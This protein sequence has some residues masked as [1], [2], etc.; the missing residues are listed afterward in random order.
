M[1]NSLR[2]LI[3]LVYALFAISGFAGLIYEALWSRYMKLLLGH[4]AYGQIL[5]LILFMGGV[6]VGSWLGGKYARILRHPLYLYALAEILIGIGGLSYHALYQGSSHLLFQGASSLAG[7]PMLLN[8]L[9]LSLAVLITV[10]WA[11]LLGVTFPALAIGLLEWQAD[12]GQAALPWLYFTNSLGGAAGVLVSSF[13]LLPHLGTPGT[14]TVAASLNLLLGLCF[15]GLVRQ[16]PQQSSG[17]LQA[18]SLH[19]PETQQASPRLLPEVHSLLEPRSL[20]RVLLV[21]SLLTGLSS[22]IYEI[23]WIRLLSLLIG[24]STQA[25]DLMLSAFILGLAVGSLVVRFV[26]KHTLKPLRDLVL[27]QWAMG[28]L[29][30][31]SLV[32]YSGIFELMNQSHAVFLRTEAAYVVFS[33]FRY[34]ICLLLMFPA[35][36]FAGMT[37]PLISWLVLRLSGQ[38]RTLGQVYALNT[39]GA[40]LGAALGGLVLMPWLQLKGTLLA[41][42]LIDIALAVGLACLMRVSLW[43]WAG[44]VALS[45]LLLWPVLTLQLNSFALSAGLFREAVDLQAQHQSHVRPPVIR[46]GR[47]ATISFHDFGHLRVLKTNGKPDASLS[48]QPDMTQANDEITQVALALYPMRLMKQPY[49]AAMIGMGSGMTAHYL[50][51]DPW[52]QKLDLIE[53][54][55]EV[56][57]LARGFLP[58]NRQ[59]YENPRLRMIFDDARTFFHRENQKYDLIVSEP[60]NPWVSGVSSLFTTEF[61]RDLKPFLKPDGLL[62]QWIHSYEFD[63]ALLLSILRAL[64]DQFPYLA[65]YGLPGMPPDQVLPSNLLIMASDR[66]QVF[67]ESSQMRAL[68]LVEADLKRLGVSSSQF[69]SIY[70]I[71]TERTLKSLI[72]QYNPNSDFFPIVDNEAEKHFFMDNKVNLYDFLVFTPVYYQS[73]FEPDFDNLLKRR[74]LK[75]ASFL[76]QALRKLDYQ[77][78]LPPEQIDRVQLRKN[79]Q[80]LY[81]RFLPVLDRNH[82]ALQKYRRYVQS[83][84]GFLALE[85]DFL[86]AFVQRN[87]Q[88]MQRQIPLLLSLPADQVNDYLVRTLVIEAMRSRDLSLFQQVMKKLVP[89]HPEMNRYEKEWLQVFLKAG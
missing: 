45:L 49:R 10:P 84:S 85:F 78:S 20:S 42:V 25:F 38:E 32:F 1:H 80:S 82:P 62:V 72:M 67:P 12:A 87:R 83:Y 76:Q 34:L 70:R 75:G 64:S 58:W 71:A 88:E 19:P 81:R 6:G 5:T 35:S 28:I 47:T 31:L 4:S 61:Y 55:P 9:K 37:L 24:S 53:I 69:D 56:Y 17:V 86:M 48:P 21:V 52:L 63:S 11:V 27:V 65:V 8:L 7:Q 44:A 13:F 3:P 46:H 23:C 79:I 36:F 14:L 40:I 16:V 66:P 51:A 18:E 41:A 57:Q 39:L 54:E 33:G 59:V 30:A 89:S 43:R 26:M 77:L 73:L 22:F 60:S 74:L 15:Y 50:L 29:A 68:P 2:Y